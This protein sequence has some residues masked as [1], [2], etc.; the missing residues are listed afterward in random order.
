MFHDHI[1]NL[2]NKLEGKS[3]KEKI[4]YFFYY[5][6]FHALGILFALFILG[7]LIS[8]LIDSKKEPSIYVA[9][10]NSG[11]FDSN[12]TELLNG[13]VLSRLID[14]D[15]HPATLDISMQLNRDTTVNVNAATSDYQVFMAFLQSGLIDVVI[16]TP[17]VVSQYASI[18]AFQ[19][20][21]DVLPSDLASQLE[22]D[23]CY[24]ETEDGE[25]VPLAI[26]VKNNP[27]VT[28][29]DAFAFED[30]VVLAL[31]TTS[32]HPE[33]GIDFIRYLYEKK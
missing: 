33:T 29:G 10:I 23:L 20:L 12:S 1:E 5:Y 6:K 18:H 26:S 4:G 19:N 32:K 25:K 2:K 21:L 17:D 7:S 3:T 15:K 24:F 11:L 8:G 22:D 30:E 13:Y 14:T 9:M 27:K 28:D 31:T 16:G